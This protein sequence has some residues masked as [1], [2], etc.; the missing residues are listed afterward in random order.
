MLSTAA[1]SVNFGASTINSQ[2]MSLKLFPKRKE[3]IEQNIVVLK[4][5]MQILTFAQFGALI[6]TF[7]RTQWHKRHETAE[8]FNKLKTRA[9]SIGGRLRS[10]SSRGGSDSS[11]NMEAAATVV[12]ADDGAAPTEDD[13]GEVGGSGNVGVESGVELRP[14][15][16][17]ASTELDDDTRIV[18]KRNPSV[19]KSLESAD[20]A[21]G[22]GTD[23]NGGD[24]AGT[25]SVEMNMAMHE[26]V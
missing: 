2:R 21:P 7:M 25:S 11:G 13:S 4:V 5:L 3:E 1:L 20:A 16:R 8:K 10:R 18:W 14:M 23:G 22:V 15:S 24:Q 19:G 9:S 12:S 17:T 6:Y 26:S